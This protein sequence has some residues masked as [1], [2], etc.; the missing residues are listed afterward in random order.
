MQ[1]LLDPAAKG[2]TITLDPIYFQQSVAEIKPESLPQLER[3]R[4]VL[5]NNPGVFVRIE[6]H[7]DNQGTPASL[8]KLSR[9]RAE[10]IRDY[11]YNKG[12]DRFRV[13]AAGFGAKRPV[14]S[15]E[16]ERGRETNRRVEVV[17]TK[18]IPPRV[19]ATVPGE[20]P[21]NKPTK[22]GDDAGR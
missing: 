11:L 6:G 21:A 5:S 13:Q 4:A 20:A 15:N 2:G 18:I 19:T 10:A 9:Q 22:A 1:I 16:S 17:I 8:E 12:I 3:L 14:A 7:T